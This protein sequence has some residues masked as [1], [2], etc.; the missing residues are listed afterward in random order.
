MTRSPAHI[1]LIFASLALAGAAVF[2]LHERGRES[3]STGTA[4]SAAVIDPDIPGE[5]WQPFEAPTPPEETDELVEVTSERPPI[6]AFRRPLAA[7]GVRVERGLREMI[8][9][10]EKTRRAEIDPASF[11]D[12][13]SLQPKD[14]VQ[15]PLLDGETVE[16]KVNLVRPD[17]D[18]WVRVGGQL[19]GKRAG[20]F[21]LGSNGVEASALVQLTRERVAYE[22]GRQDDG[23]TMMVEKHLGNVL[24]L[25][26]PPMYGENPPQIVPRAPQEAPPI[27]NS[28]PGETATIYLD[29]D[30]EVVNDPNWNNGNTINAAAANIS[31]GDITTVF[32]RVKEDFWPFRINLTTDLAKYNAAPVNRRT[33]CI[34]TP[35]NTAAPGAG[36]VAYIDAFSNAGNFFSTT[37]PCWVFNGGVVGMS[38]AISHEVGHTLGLLHDGRTTPNEQYYLGHGNG[39]TGWCP[40]MGAGYYKPCVQWSKGE[41]TAANNQEDDLQLITRP[42]N[43]FGYMLDDAG[44]TKATAAILTVTNPVEQTGVIER[45]TDVDLY[46][47]AT[48]GGS[49]TIN[50]NPAAPS[51]NLDISLSILDADL[52]VVTSSNPPGALNAGISN[53]NLPGGQYYIRVANSGAPAPP[54]TGYTAYA[55][56]GYYRMIGI[57]QGFSQGLV[58]TSG[59]SITSEVDEDFRYQITTS[60]TPNSYGVTG[61]LPAGLSIDTQTGLISGIAT[62]IGVFNVTMTASDNIV[63]ATKPLE[64]EVTPHILTIG[65]AV[66]ATT[67]TWVSTGSTRWFG[68]T[69]INHDGVNAAQSGA[70]GAGQESAL[71]TEVVGPTVINFYWKFSSGQSSTS[72][73]FSLDD[74]VQATLQGRVDWTQRSVLV[75]SGTHTLRWRYLRVSGRDSGTDGAWIDEVAVDPRPFIIRPLEVTA[76]VGD[77]FS[78]QIEVTNPPATLMIA[79][80]PSWLTF[81]S[82]TRTLSGTPPTAGVVPVLITSQNGFGSVDS[83]LMIHVDPVTPGSDLLKGAT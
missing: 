31:N 72:L 24:C 46:Y 1:I 51:P 8:R 25:P 58:I 68:Q 6:T 83:N 61:A 21:T 75:P 11:A 47:F 37:I 69:D 62:Q 44:A 53:F 40:I 36:G 63:T 12:L 5:A 20:S 82:A 13:G 39:P 2:L 14:L 67:F 42:Q 34:I 81:D 64:I 60:E 54:N 27:L 29:F 57:I 70:L 80:L 55:S 66:N 76:R 77:L 17:S 35:T 33:R 26:L 74:K 19:T 59:S 9:N 48:N 52:N 50:A 7:T 3:P 28:R 4:N 56:L 23:R 32:N 10:G 43:G 65:E 41:Y 49:I 18:G 30:G 15:L 45:T 71:A 22:V 79:N 78:H 16:G 73:E 38:E